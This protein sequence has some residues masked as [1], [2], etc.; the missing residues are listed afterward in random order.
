MHDLDQRSAAIRLV[1][2]DVDGV[3][4]DGSIL[5][6]GGE[7]LKSFHVRDGLGLKRLLAAGI[8]VAVVSGRSSA[9][10]SQRMA[11]LGVRF[12]FQGV[13]D[14]LPV[15]E[16]LRE[17]LGIEAAEVAVVGDDLPDVPAMESAGLAIAVAD[18]QPEVRALAHWVTTAAGGRGAAREVAERLLSAR[19]APREAVR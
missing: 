11:E 1:V 13:D 2:L 17:G 10:V 6:G 8:E 18:A 7:E 5:L 4:T 9:A 12:V 19:A 14:K 16:R 3:L 15:I